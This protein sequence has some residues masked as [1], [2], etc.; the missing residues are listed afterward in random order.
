MPSPG[1]DE[2]LDWLS[3]R[4]GI[5]FAA[6]ARAFGAFML[7]PLLAGQMFPR[8]V[9]TAIPIALLPL[10]LAAPALADRPGLALESGL[11]GVLLAEL[12]YGLVLSLPA[13]VLFWAAHAAGELIDIQTGANNNQVFNPMSQSMDGPAAGLFLQLAVFGFI[14]FGGLHEHVRA[15]VTSYAT[16]PVGAIARFDV[17]VLPA[18]AA[19][20]VDQTLSIA[21]RMAAPMLGIFLVVEFAFGLLAKPLPQLPVPALAAAVKSLLLPLVL[22]VVLY[23]IDGYL[24][25]PRRDLLDLTPFF[26]R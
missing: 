4:G 9:R 10:L 13:G 14:A 2:L 11:V 20:L 18:A 25:P 12:V 16:V 19:A 22:L 21:I 17:T 6:H 24:R 3:A 5:L 15:L 26:S 8:Q 7:L 1:W 23:A